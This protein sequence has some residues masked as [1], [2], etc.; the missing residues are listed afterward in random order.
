MVDI[1]LPSQTRLPN[2]CSALIWQ[3]TRSRHKDRISF[4]ILLMTRPIKL[5]MQPLDCEV[6]FRTESQDPG[7]NKNTLNILSSTC[8]R[9]VNIW[10]HSLIYN[11]EIRLFFALLLPLCLSFS[12]NS[13]ASWNR[14]NIF[15]ETCECLLNWLVNYPVS[16]PDD[17]RAPIRL[18]LDVARPETSRHSQTPWRRMEWK[19]VGQE[20][21]SKTQLDP[22]Q[23]DSLGG[24]TDRQTETHKITLR[25]KTGPQTLT[26]YLHCS[27]ILQ[28][29][30][31]S[32]S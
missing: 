32:V 27:D 8:C 12:R 18:A 14:R 16:R 23:F 6:A 19:R 28:T 4:G 26:L 30:E 25:C 1:C 22:F 24:S 31:C 7:L 10:R 5:Y 3:S 21:G 17:C 2:C 13:V 20:E 9:T 11:T 29:I 15:V